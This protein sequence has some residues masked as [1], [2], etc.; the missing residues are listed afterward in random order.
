MC[1]KLLYRRVQ[2]H[3][4]LHHHTQREW[5]GDWWAREHLAIPRKQYKMLTAYS[6]HFRD[7]F[8][9][10]DLKFTPHRL[11]S[12]QYIHRHW[13]YYYSSVLDHLS[14]VGH[15]LEF[16]YYIAYKPEISLKSFYHIQQ[17]FMWFSRTISICDITDLSSRLIPHRTKQYRKTNRNDTDTIPNTKSALV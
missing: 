2:K 10:R 15:H 1:F 3:I 16:Y 12:S 17:C 4:L 13:F 6:F 11:L 5:L 14:L 9:Y 8:V 7:E